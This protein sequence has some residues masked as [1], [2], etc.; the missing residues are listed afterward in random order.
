MSG[1]TPASDPRFARREIAAK[2]ISP[3]SRPRSRS[4]SATYRRWRTRSGTRFP[5]APTRVVSSAPMPPTWASTAS[6]SPTTTAARRAPPGESGCRSG[7]SRCR[8]QAWSAGRGSPVGSSSRLSASSWSRSWSASLW[9]V[10]SGD[11]SSLVDRGQATGRCAE[12]HAQAPTTASKPGVAV[13]L[14]ATAEVWVCLLD[15]KEESLVD[16]QILEEGAEAGPFRSKGFEVALGNGSVAMFVD[17]KRAHVPE[18]SSPV[19]Y[20]VDSGGKLTLLGRRRK[21][22]LRMTGAAPVRAGIVVTGTEVLT[23][24]IADRNGPWIS[25]QLAELGVDVAHIT[26]VGDRPEDLEAALRFMAGEGMDLIVTS[27]GLGPDRRRPDRGDRRPL[28]RCGAGARRRDG[29]EDRRDPARLRAPLPLR[30]GGSA[31]G[32]SQAGDDSGGIAATRSGRDRAGA[33][34]AGGRS[35]GGRAARTAARAAAD[36]A[37]GGRVASGTGGS[38]PRHAAALLHAA[39]VRHSRVGDRQEPARDRGWWG[40]AGQGRDHHLPAPRRDRDRRPLPR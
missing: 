28:R 11:S 12:K 23:G 4:A 8:P 18:S 13:R 10:A 27:G 1:W 38:R 22:N 37:A 21:A 33:G 39:D 17:G 7:S 3:R 29:G 31:G 32:K 40:R 16:G 19:G 6:A 9:P 2:S 15:A 14:T 20:R 24:R 30:R 25:E 5:V 35:G 26:V 36:V 34:G